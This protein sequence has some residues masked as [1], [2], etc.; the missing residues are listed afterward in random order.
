MTQA[1]LQSGT[2]H[3]PYEKEKFSVSSDHPVAAKQRSYERLQA[4]SLSAPD[5][6]FSPIDWSPHAPKPYQQKNA[7]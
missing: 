1:G 4:S 2:F 3:F 5:R 6:S 7:V